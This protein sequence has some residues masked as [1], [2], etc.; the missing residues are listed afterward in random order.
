[1]LPCFKSLSDQWLCD[2]I[3]FVVIQ[4]ERNMLLAIE[5]ESNVGSRNGLFT[6]RKDEHQKDGKDGR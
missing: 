1:V 6:R 4:A 2:Q 3:P 5:A